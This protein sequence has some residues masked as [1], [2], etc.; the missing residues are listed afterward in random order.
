MKETE[1]S[2]LVITTKNTPNVREFY[3]QFQDQLEFKENS[4]ILVKSKN[5]EILGKITELT[6]SNPLYNDSAFIDEIMT[7][8]IDPTD[9]YNIKTLCFGK[10]KTLQQISDGFLRLPDTPVFPGDRVFPAPRKM[11]AKFLKLDKGIHLGRL[12]ERTDVEIQLDFDKFLTQHV[13]VLGATG[14]GKSYTNG[15][16]VEEI[17]LNKGLPMIIIDPHGEYTT[18]SDLADRNRKIYINFIAPNETSILKK[19]FSNALVNKYSFSFDPFTTNTRFFSEL[20]DATDPQKDLIYLAV[21][22]RKKQKL[23]QKRLINEKIDDDFNIKIKFRRLLAELDQIGASHE[24]DPK[25]IRTTKR[26]LRMLLERKFLGKELPFG[27]FLKKN[28]INI[29][30]VSESE[31]DKTMRTIV[32]ILLDKILYYKKRFRNTL[33]V[34]ILI[35]EAHNF[36]PQNELTPSKTIIRRI[37]REGR[38]FGLFLIL[39]SQ[40]IVGLDKDVLS[41][42]NTKLTLKVDSLTDINY[43]RPYLSFRSEKDFQKLAD[44]PTGVAFISGTSVPSPTLVR[45]KKRMTRDGG[46]TPSLNT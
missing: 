16:I 23:K 7:H 20:I 41:Q 6:T 33:P 35:E 21:N 17:A 29:I 42:C 8:D 27:E 30:D 44:L 31:D 39:T 24:F 1:K 46:T 40:R 25:T 11:I 14:S 45:I 5:N 32:A 37:G 9:L 38:K 26:K 43:I 22:N 15:V 34:V 12:F 18:L 10:V 4:F 2:G 36:C 3:F 13:A 19:K 28:T